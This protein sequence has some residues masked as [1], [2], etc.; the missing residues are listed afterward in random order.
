LQFGNVQTPKWIASLVIWFAT[1]A[2]CVA[3]IVCVYGLARPETLLYPFR[4]RAQQTSAA[5]FTAAAATLC[6]AW[7]IWFGLSQQRNALSKALYVAFGTGISYAAFSAIGLQICLADWRSPL[8]LIFPSTF[9]AEYNWLAFI[10]EVA[11]ATSCF[12]GLL[13]FLL[14]KDGNA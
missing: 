9:F 1:C 4:T 5:C 3:A 6:S 11:P 13:V 8:N 7:A 14:V 2:F 10:F 12:V